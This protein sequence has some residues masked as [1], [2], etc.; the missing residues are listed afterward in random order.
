MVFALALAGCGGTPTMVDSRAGPSPVVLQ[1]PTPDQLAVS[2]ALNLGGYD[3]ATRDQALLDV[4]FQHDGRPVRFVAGERVTCGGVA[5]KAYVGSFESH[6]SI[7]TVAA[8]NLSCTYSWKGGSAP[9][10]I[11]VP[12]AL[13]VLV[14]M[15]HQAVARG[16]ETVVRFAGATGGEIWVVALSPSA[17]ANATTT[18]G[19][20]VL[21]TTRLAAGEGSIAVTDANNI[22]LTSVQG[23]AFQSLTGSLRRMTS[24]AVVWT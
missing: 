18:I 16:R 22:A 2:V 24:V 13:T 7:A 10:V 5:M 14:P 9:L 17:K 11:G 23:P 20:A 15:E 4:M 12:S 1:D 21:D 6:L 3:L 19:Q 8:R